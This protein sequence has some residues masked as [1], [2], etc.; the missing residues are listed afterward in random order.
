ME[1]VDC[2]LIHLNYKYYEGWGRHLEL[3][4]KHLQFQK[5]SKTKLVLA[6]PFM[7]PIKPGES[8]IWMSAFE[9]DH[10]PQEFVGPANRGIAMI[11][12]TEWGK[13]AF[14]N[15]GVTIPI[16]VCPEGITD[17]RYW[18]PP[19][20]PFTFLHFDCTSAHNRKG[21]DL[22]LEAFSSVFG[23]MQG[24]A[25][26]IMKGQPHRNYNPKPQPNVEYILEEYSPEEMVE[27]WKKTN[28][29]VFPSRGEG[30]GLPPLEAMG[31][32][33]PTILTN[34]SG[35]MPFARKGIP[36]RV[37][38]KI[39]AEY[40]GY[41]GVGCWDEPDREQLAQMMGRVYYNYEEEKENAK[42]QFYGIWKDYNFAH[43]SLTLAKI[44]NGIKK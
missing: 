44:I 22:V 35:M 5:N 37:D 31:H 28:C 23:N 30:F 26:L 33:I 15:S 17:D 12:P 2:Q 41:H 6:N 20:D 10:V 32:S 27:L 36:I 34:G 1:K 24:K 9:A 29:F 11:V 39:A 4:K 7:Y 40:E 14:I 42:L 38:R 18:N 21:S 19:T 13:N 3:L 25:K 16:Y 8:V 43:V